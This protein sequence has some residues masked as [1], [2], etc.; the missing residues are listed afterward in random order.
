MMIR[1]D[2]EGAL[3]IARELVA[4]EGNVLSIARDRAGVR[5]AAISQE[6][7]IGPEADIANEGADRTDELLRELVPKLDST[8]AA[9]AA[10]WAYVIGEQNQEKYEQYAEIVQRENQSKL[11]SYYRKRRANPDAN[12]RYP[13]L[14]S[15]DPPRP[16]MPPLRAQNFEPEE[17]P[18]V[19]YS[20]VGLDYVA[21]YS[22]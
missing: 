18:F 2:F 22:W 4:T 19:S 16:V 7:F 5:D 13:R 1:F 6:H 11:Q 21:S 17:P 10:E 8:A 12:H 20:R 3:D 14:G 9:W 15:I